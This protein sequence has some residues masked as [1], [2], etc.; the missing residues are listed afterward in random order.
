MTKYKTRQL[1]K[2]IISDGC[3][4]SMLILIVRQDIEIKII[5][6]RYISKIM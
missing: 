3:R 6:L 5:K 1:R 2:S 4:I